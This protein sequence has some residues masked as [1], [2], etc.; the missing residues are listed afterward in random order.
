MSLF[1]LRGLV[2]VMHRSVIVELNLTSYRLERA[3]KNNEEAAP[4]QAG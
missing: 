4:A 3:T 2:P 1:G